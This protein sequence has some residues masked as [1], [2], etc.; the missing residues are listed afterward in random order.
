MSSSKENADEVIPV[1]KSV[2]LN[3]KKTK[4]LLKGLIIHQDEIGMEGRKLMYLLLAA[5]IEP[6][7]CEKDAT[8][9]I[10]TNLH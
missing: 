7:C 4:D 6:T 10:Q 3:Q 1:T 8:N 9:I 5:G 2:N